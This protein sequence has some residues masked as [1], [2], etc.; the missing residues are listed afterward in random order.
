MALSPL[1][2]YEIAKLGGKSDDPAECAQ[3]YADS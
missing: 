3:A 1:Q 2:V